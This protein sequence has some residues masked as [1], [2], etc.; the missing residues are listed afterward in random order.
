MVGRKS[1]AFDTKT[2]GS[3]GGSD[4]EKTRFQSLSSWPLVVLLSRDRRSIEL[5]K[6]NHATSM[7]AQAIGIPRVIYRSPKIADD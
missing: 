5:W 2:S 1:G 7:V 4:V 3:L 6:A